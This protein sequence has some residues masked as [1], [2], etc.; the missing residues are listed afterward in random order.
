VDVVTL[1]NTLRRVRSLGIKEYTL[2]LDRCFVNQGN[3][4]EL[5]EDKSLFVILPSRALK[6]VEEALTMAQRDLEIL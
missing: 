5:V 4:E 1:K 2:V 6:S 3:L